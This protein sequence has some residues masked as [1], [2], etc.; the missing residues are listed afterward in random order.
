[1][2]HYLVYEIRFNRG[3]LEKYYLGSIE[4]PDTIT[5][6]THYSTGG[7]VQYK[8]CNFYETNNHSK[9]YFVRAYKPKPCLGC[10]AA[11]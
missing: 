11:R 5:A 8:K 4:A 7:V 9:H 3:N 2:K 10:K 1:M 6:V